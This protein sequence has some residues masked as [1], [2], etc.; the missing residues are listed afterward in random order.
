MRSRIFLPR[1]TAP[2]DQVLTRSARIGQGGQSIG[3]PGAKTA[4]SSCCHKIGMIRR[5]NLTRP[6][7]SGQGEAEIQDGE[8]IAATPVSLRKH[9]R[10]HSADHGQPERAVLDVNRTASTGGARV[11]RAD[12]PE[13]PSLGGRCFGWMT[14]L[15]ITPGSDSGQHEEEHGDPWRATDAL[16]R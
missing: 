14:L 3:S 13:K 5:G 11:S 15:A 6:G 2:T 10:Q 9:E 16:T 1:P 12:F 8:L 4:S 7:R